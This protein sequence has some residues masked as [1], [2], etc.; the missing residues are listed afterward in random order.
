MFTSK[1]GIII[2]TLLGICVL[3][4]LVYYLYLENKNH[5]KNS[6]VSKNT[7]K[8]VEDKVYNNQKS[9]ENKKLLDEIEFLKNRNK[10]LNSII[11]RHSMTIGELKYEL[12]KME[13]V[14]NTPENATNNSKTE[15]E[16]II[17]K[18]VFSDFE[19]Y[20]TNPKQA[21]KNFVNEIYER[22]YEGKRNSKEWT[23]NKGKDFELFIGKIYELSG[24]DV[25]YNGIEAHKKRLSDYG[26]DLIVERDGHKV[27]IQCKH[28]AK[29]GKLPVGVS[30]D[31]YISV[32]K[33]DVNEFIIYSTVQKISRPLKKELFENKKIILRNNWQNLLF[34]HLNKVAPKLFE[35]LNISQK[36]F[37]SLIE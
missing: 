23:D 29:D 33:F 31:Y 7:S 11:T 25:I 1:I 24:Y 12:K 34:K 9:S 16:S 15:N 19:L 10:E 26:T 22:D 13:M 37:K 36:D 4:A 5:N 3:F 21:I 20:H 30:K 17:Y 35:E 2:W 18:K 14:K 32:E 8:K 27:A 6:T 28:Y